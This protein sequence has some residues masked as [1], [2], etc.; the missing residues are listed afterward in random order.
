[1]ADKHDDRGSAGLPDRNNFRSE[2][3]HSLFADEAR[4]KAPD[5]LARHQDKGSKPRPRVFSRLIL[6]AAIFLIGVA[7]IAWA[8]Q[9]LPSRGGR[10][11]PAA[12][13]DNE[14]ID[15]LVFE[16][17]RD[18]ERNVLWLHSPNDAENTTQ[19][20]LGTRGQYDFKFSNVTAREVQLGVFEASCGCSG[21]QVCVFQDAQQKEQYEKG[22]EGAEPVWTPVD[23]DRTL[24]NFATIPPKA[25]GILRVSW[26]GK[27]E[28]GVLDLKTQVWSRAMGGERRSPVRLVIVAN[29]VRPVIFDIQRLDLGTLLPGDTATGSFYCWSATRDL[30]VGAGQADPRVKIDATRLEDQA[31][32][33]LKNMLT[34]RGMFTHVC[35]GYKVN[36]TLFEQQEGKQLDLGL[37]LKPAPL[38]IKVDGMAI[39]VPL[40]MLR[41]FVRGEVV[42]TGPED[43][44][45]IDLKIFSAKYGTTK[46]VSLLAPKGAKLS[47][48]GCEPALLELDVS[49]SPLETTGDKTHWQMELVVRPGGLAGPLPEDGV[50]V[51][52]LEQSKAGDA[53]A[54]VRE[55]RIPVAGTA[56]S[57]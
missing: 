49:L 36:V 8:A 6:P 1:M 39:D 26:S 5:S 25:E 50:V 17:L 35:A 7:F 46:R 28:P 3:G 34:Q 4:G 16:G 41:A 23:V 18:D 52:R 45:R 51:L 53:P 56:G 31:C 10:S 37:M 55:V 29:Y 40:P 19:F 11:R 43:S 24:R 44:G 20:E 13:S 57:H 22:K 15:A 38:T 47:F 27:T 32:L 14:V 42:L 30:V 9:Y 54:K 21:V 48:A 33:E 12:E 2:E